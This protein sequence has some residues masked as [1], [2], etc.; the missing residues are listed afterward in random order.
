M[1]N[2]NKSNSEYNEVLQA[3]QRLFS[4]DPNLNK[5]FRWPSGMQ[6]RGVNSCRGMI[7]QMKLAFK[8]I[9]DNI[10]VIESGAFGTFVS[11]YHTVLKI[12]INYSS[13][14]QEQWERKWDNLENEIKVEFAAFVK[15]M[16]NSSFINGL[17]LYFQK[18]IELNEN[19]INEFLSTITDIVNN[20]LRKSYP[21]VQDEIKK[22]YNS[23]ELRDESSSAR[24][25]EVFDATKTLYEQIKEKSEELDRKFDSITIQASI[26]NIN[27]ALKKTNKPFWTFVSLSVLAILGVFCIIAYAALHINTPFNHLENHKDWALEIKKMYL[28]KNS[29][30][31][32]SAIALFSGIFTYSLKMVKSYLNIRTAYN[33]KLALLSS[34]DNLV[35]KEILN[36]QERHTVTETL[37]KQIISGDNISLGD[38]Q[39]S[40]PS[41]VQS[42]IEKLPS[43]DKPN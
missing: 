4:D 15:Q 6:E 40:A 36:S 18:Q 3:E 24:Y 23:M 12:L 16:A 42:I 5:V 19:Q 21:T 34:F 13:M 32:L 30:I 27:D 11:R 37:I 14:P 10:E 26:K 29:L 8:V 9:R 38:N 41:I 2:D 33:H 1:Y 25:R 43:S 35:G 20:E 7:N 39:S 31:T 17:L 28:I 22:L